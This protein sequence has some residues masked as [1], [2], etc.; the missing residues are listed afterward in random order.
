MRKMA[1]AALA[2]SLAFIVPGIA[3]AK[4]AGTVSIGY[5]HSSYDYDNSYYGEGYYSCYYCEDHEQGPTL[6]AS[7]VGPLMGDGPWI[8][9]GDAQLVSETEHYD[10]ESYKSHDSVGHV[11]AHGALPAK[12][13]S[14]S[15]RKCSPRSP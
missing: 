11:A 7:V 8:I 12:R 5:E 6:S 10:H 9:Q 3:S 13:A 15:R 2:A 4:I 1:I 14:T